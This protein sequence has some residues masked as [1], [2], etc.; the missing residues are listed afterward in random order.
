MGTHIISKSPRSRNGV[1]QYSEA[2]LKAFNIPSRHNRITVRATRQFELSFTRLIVAKGQSGR[3]VSL[4]DNG[5]LMLI[6]FGFSQA[7]ARIPVD[8]DLV[9]F[10]T[11]AEEFDRLKT[12]VS[13]FDAGLSELE[14]ACADLAQRMEAGR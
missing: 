6:D 4:I 7:V 5:R 10:V 14:Q 3:V 11:L 8:S 12:A 1:S 13:Q 2:F 9:E